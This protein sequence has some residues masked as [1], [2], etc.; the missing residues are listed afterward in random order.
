MPTP[1]EALNLRLYGS[2]DQQYQPGGQKT[3]VSGD[4]FKNGQGP[5]VKGLFFGT[6]T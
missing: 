4:Y 6:G 2:W 5:A 3:F 1:T